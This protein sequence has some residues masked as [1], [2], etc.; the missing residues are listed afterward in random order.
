MTELMAQLSEKQAELDTARTHLQQANGETTLLQGALGSAEKRIIDLVSERNQLEE[1]RKILTSRIKGMEDEEAKKRTTITM[2]ERQVE[3]QDERI[4]ALN[5]MIQNL[6]ETVAII[7]N[8]LSESQS[9]L[10]ALQAEA[11]GLRKNLVNVKESAE[12]LEAHLEKLTNE[13]DELIAQNSSQKAEG[14]GLRGRIV[15]METRWREELTGRDERITELSSALEAS[16][17]RLDE[18]EK[19]KDIL[20][21]K[22]TEANQTITGLRDQLKEVIT[23]VPELKDRLEQSL[24]KYQ[25]VHENLTEANVQKARLEAQ[26]KAMKE[27]YEALVSGLKQQLDSKEASIEEYREKFKVTFINR[28]LFGFSQTRISP[29]GMA[30]L[31]QLA[32]VLTDVPE[33]K[34]SI[35]GHADNIAIAEKFQYRFPSNWELSSARAA[36]VARYLLEQGVLEPSRIEVIGLSRYHPIANNDTEKGRSKNRRVEIIIT[37]GR[38]SASENQ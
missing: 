2:L 33:G 29:E 35:I 18:L 32:G 4:T 22:L 31:D 25:A 34:I 9:S 27:T 16:S 37:P 14:D 12:G 15:E 36:A 26:Q 1:E 28:I 13:R 21:T 10:W 8:Q 20:I 7:E 23:Q 19:D 24:E 6:R 17:E 30:A 3:E 38:Y 11:D 5:I